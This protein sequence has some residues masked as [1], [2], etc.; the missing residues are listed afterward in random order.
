MGRGIEYKREVVLN[1][2]ERISAARSILLVGFS[3]V[4]VAEVTQLRDK[5]RAAKVDYIVAKNSLIK[6]A[7]VGTPFESLEPH[8]VGPT[9]LGIGYDGS[10]AVVKI[11]W[12]LTKHVEGLTIKAGYVDGAYASAGDVEVIAKL[13]SKAELTAKLLGALQSPITRLVSVMNGPISA[14]VRTL[15]AIKK[16]K[17]GGQPAE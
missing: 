13:P 9:A 12:D 1:L 5:V 17:E 11:L 3:G 2:T 10:L 7:M 6:R 16:K 4:S 15:N 14:F 8:L